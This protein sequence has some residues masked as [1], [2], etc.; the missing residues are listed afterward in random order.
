[1]DSLLAHLARP[2]ALLFAMVMAVLLVAFAAM[3]VTQLS[4]HAVAGSDISPF[5]WA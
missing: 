1:M 4:G 2:T 3:V 5:R